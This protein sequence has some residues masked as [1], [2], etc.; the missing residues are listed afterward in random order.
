MGGSEAYRTTLY[1][2]QRGLQTNLHADEHSG[3]LIQVRGVKRVVL[4]T[5]KASRSL[6]CSSWGDVNTPISRRSWFDSGVPDVSD[7]AET[8]PFASL[9]GREVEVGPGEALYIPRG[10][11][12]DVLSRSDETLGLVL[13][14]S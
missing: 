9:D 10:F 4:F 12:H 11:F 13:R 2:S 3:F 7:W 6:R 1:A 14:C 5:P 8:P